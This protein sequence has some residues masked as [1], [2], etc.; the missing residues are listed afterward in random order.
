MCACVC[1]SQQELL[2]QREQM[3]S[4]LVLQVVS[5]QESTHVF[6]ADVLP[7]PF[8]ASI[9]LAWARVVQELS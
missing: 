1:V 4:D 5:D 8:G 6:V 9:L 7:S 3:R 2:V